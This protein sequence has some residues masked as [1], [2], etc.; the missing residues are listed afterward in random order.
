MIDVLRA[1]AEEVKKA[2]SLIPDDQKG[3]NICIGADGTP[4]EEIDKVAENAVLRYI[5]ANNIQLNVLSEEIGYVDNGA[6]ETLVLDPI[7]GTTNSIVG[8]PMYTVSM[9]IGKSSLND[10]HTALIYNLATGEEFMAM[11][12][13]GA[14]QNGKRI[15]VKRDFVQDKVRMSIYLGRGANP[16]AFALA[17]R[18][19]STRSFGC[20]SLEMALV[21]NGATDGFL[22]QSDSYNRSMRVVDIAASA[23]ILREAGGEVYTLD[24]N[25]LDMPF[26][27][28]TRMNF[29][30]VS[31]RIVFDFVMNGN[32]ILSP[33]RGKLRYG[34][35]ANMKLN[36]VVGVTRRVV[37]AL[38]DEEYV[39]DVP[40]ADAMGLKGVSVDQMDIDA[41]ITIGGDG[42]ILRALHNIEVPV[43]GINAGGVGFLTE[44]SKDE[45]ESGI[46][47]LLRGE[48]TIQ[49]R[50]KIAVMY[51]GEI[52]G[53][54]VNE[55]VIHSDSVAKIRRFK[56]Y[57]NDS[58]TTDIRADGIVLS[59]PVG[60]TS[61]AMSLGGP[62]M[63]H[64]V[65][66]WL[67]V[68]M[69]A[70][71]FA[72]KEMV[73]PSSV[74]ITIEAVLDKGCLLVIDG[75]NEFNIPGGS[76]IDL[77]KSS[78]RALFIVFETDFY[79]RVRKKLVSTL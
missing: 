46:A 74:K 45:I 49:S 18:I 78:R 73:V 42:T 10:V 38:G 72:F 77:V 14:Y 11:K 55:A 67:M 56:V 58:L 61:Y 68:P 48:Y 31:N 75:Q 63:D 51:N 65:D 4:T 62:I 7:D 41:L 9:A 12:G 29:L 37:D 79:S 28:T 2:V 70:F 33:Q 44:I 64:R 22:M 76:K 30:A 20:S 57:V 19:R 52:I 3:V 35:Y 59:T 25:L 40:I 39:L 43:I 8:I 26:D 60:S 50:P 15:H 23:L 13:K 5:A 21:A 71:Q 66:A 6:D 1:M 17:K 69:A 36:D 54:A 47:R 34:I 27:L 16:L 53:E 32:M 24:G